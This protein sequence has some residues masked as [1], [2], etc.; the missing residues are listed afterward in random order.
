MNEIE[1]KEQKIHCPNKDLAKRLLKKLHELGYVWL[2]GCELWKKTEWDE[3]DED[4]SYYI[5]EISKKVTFDHVFA[6]NK[7]LAINGEDWL[8]LH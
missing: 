5:D 6:I 7:D 3:F 8:N 1:Y 2:S 4:T